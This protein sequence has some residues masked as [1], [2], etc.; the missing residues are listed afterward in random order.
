[1]PR[2]PVLSARDVLKVLRRLGF[3]LLRR[4]GSHFQLWHEGRRLLV[5]VPNHAELAK[6][7]VLSI[8]KQA[9][10]TKEEFLKEL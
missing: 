4:S 6:G 5:T 8:F 9:R 3:E 1:V 10:V 7:T 2:L